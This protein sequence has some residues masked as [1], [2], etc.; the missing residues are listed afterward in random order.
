M[1]LKAI[2]SAA[3]I[4]AACAV[5]LG[6]SH[7]ARP[8]GSGA[9]GEADRPPAASVADDGKKVTV[10]LAGKLF[11]EYRY[12]GFAKPILYPVIGPTGVGMTRN[13]P[14]RKGVKGEAADHV[15]HKSLWLAHGDVNGV[16][17][18]L[19]G[20]KRGKIVHAELLEA[21]AD[22]GRAVIRTRNNWVGPDGKTVCADERTM[23]FSQWA[24]GRIIDFEIALIAS[25]GDV[26]FGDTKEGFMAIR[27]CPP[28][29]LKNDKK[30]GVTGAGGRAVNS[31]GVRDK[32]I[33]GKRARWVAYWGPVAGKVVG[34]AIFDHPGNPRHPTWWHARD[35]GLITAN[36]FGEHHFENKRGRPGDMKIPAGGR[37]T[38]RYRFYF[39]TSDARAAGIAARYA[40]Y[41]AAK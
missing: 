12:T 20:A 30:R 32:A 23:T 7:A 1:H 21:R 37:R 3:C 31:E 10:R 18:W 9:A 28:L 36:P 4:P 19:E 27:T 16:D 35:Y 40:E 38:F 39:H 33:W 14:I 34:V 24:G 8:A 11:T 22:G 15:H 26:T 2:V 25:A 17:F 13:W 5:F 41:A 6:W 29:R